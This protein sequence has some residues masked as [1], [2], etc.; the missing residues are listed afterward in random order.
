LRL[1]GHFL[2]QR[3]LAPHNQSIPVGRARLNELAAHESK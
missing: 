2:A 3:V 1:T